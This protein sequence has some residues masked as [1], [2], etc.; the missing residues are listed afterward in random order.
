MHGPGLAW[1]VNVW[2]MVCGVWGFNGRVD[3]DSC[4]RGFGKFVV[5]RGRCCS[6]RLVLRKDGRV[7]GFV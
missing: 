6:G 7:I 3:N 2:C 5:I 1:M 4:S